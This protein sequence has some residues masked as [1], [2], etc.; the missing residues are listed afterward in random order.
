MQP[1]RSWMNTSRSSAGRFTP[2]ELENVSA[3]PTSPLPIG[4]L[5]GELVEPKKYG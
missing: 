4:K 1:A 3:G 2:R 5:F